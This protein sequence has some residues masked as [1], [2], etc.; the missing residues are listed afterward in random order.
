VGCQIVLGNTCTKT[1]GEF[2]NNHKIY[3]M[4]EKYTKW[5]KKIPN[6]RKIYQQFL[7]QGPLKH[8]QTDWDIWY[9]N[10]YT[11]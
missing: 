1:G 9:E 10:T 2:P 8:T 5:P 11:I 7:C 3:Q 6:G 4:A